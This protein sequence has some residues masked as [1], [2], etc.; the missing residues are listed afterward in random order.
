[1]AI[2]DNCP[3]CQ[4]TGYTCE[5]HREEPFQHDNCSGSVGRV[6]ATPNRKMRWQKVFATNDREPTSPS[7]RG[8]DLRP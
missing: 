8:R 1:M 4:G 6:S 7:N 2:D 3:K 5:D